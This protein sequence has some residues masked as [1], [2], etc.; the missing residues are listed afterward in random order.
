MFTNTEAL[1]VAA[2]FGVLFASIIIFKV[3]GFLYLHFLKPKA[4]LKKYGAGAGSWA[5]V[6]G[7]TDGIGKGF[8]QVLAR[9]GF[10]IVLVS[11]SEEKLR[12]VAKELEDKYKVKTKIVETDAAD[13]S[14]RPIRAVLNSV[15]DVPLTVLVNNVGVNT[16]IPGGLPE[17][18]DIE[19]DNIIEVNIRFTARLTR[20]L[21]G[22]LRKN[23]HSLVINVSSSS[24]FG[25]PLMPVYS[26]SK[27]FVDSFSRSLA[28]ELRAEGV[29]VVST[30]AHYVVSNMSKFKRTSFFVPSPV[31]FADA[32][33]NKVDCGPVVAP[34]WTH[35]LLLRAMSLAPAG[36]LGNHTLGLMK[37]AR[38]RLLNKAK[39]Q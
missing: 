12:E 4:S 36:W 1:N 37:A 18:S 27:A 34:Y 15:Q 8:A 30:V 35:D 25:T 17:H 22:A 32:A 21:L 19:F 33:M 6:T 13:P 23:K 11:R 3:L 2:G 10:D 28:P 16:A 5:L 24:A 26:A 39:S 29:T 38:R 9:R 20:A 14:D 7:A 31:T